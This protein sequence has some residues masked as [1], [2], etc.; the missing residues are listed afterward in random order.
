MAKTAPKR[1]P[2]GVDSWTNNGKGLVNVTPAISRAEAQRINKEVAE[3][4]KRRK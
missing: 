2:G 4:L 1:G 3:R